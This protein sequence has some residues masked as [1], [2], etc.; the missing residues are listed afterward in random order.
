MKSKE[1]KQCLFARIIA[2]PIKAFGKARDMYVRSVTKCG[3]SMCSNV[4]MDGFGGYSTFPRSYST[5]SSTRSEENDDFAELIRVASAR[6]MGD[7]IGMSLD[8]KKHQQQQQ[9]RQKQQ[10]QKASKGLLKSSSVGLAKIDEDK[11]FEQDYYPRSRSHAV[12]KT[13]SAF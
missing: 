5:G 9:Q 10:Q 1:H 4:P 3:Q 2:S 7:R 11:P 8:M 6:T 13:N 12:G